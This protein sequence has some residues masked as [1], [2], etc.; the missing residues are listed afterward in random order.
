[1]T[2]RRKLRQ[3]TVNMLASHSDAPLVSAAR[4]VAHRI[5]ALLH[6]ENHDIRTNGEARVLRCLD[7]GATT[8]VDVG[9]NRGT[10]AL[11]CHQL[12]PRADIYCFEI[13]SATRQRLRENVAAVGS[14]Y[15]HDSGLWDAAG[16]TRVKYYPERD[17]VTSIYDYPHPG[18]S[19][20]GEERVQT[21]DSVLE[22]LRLSHVDLLKIDTEGADFHVLRGFEAALSRDAVSAV[23]FE[24]GYACILARKLLID[25][26]EYL[27][28]KGF[29]IGKVHS[30][31]VDFRPYRLL[32]ENF[33]GPN[34]LAVHRS[35]QALIA[36]LAA[37]AT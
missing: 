36:R 9:A 12:V 10:W 5:T 18:A 13:A 15:V 28:P 2:T 26:Y 25:F 17:V 14:I 22:E 7:P 6:T 37:C 34:F 31:R 33:F 3:W 20:W 19:V 24:Y 27:E 16:V 32:D 11:L 30:R 23:Q 29:V 1:M 8:I 21:G 35:R 4:N